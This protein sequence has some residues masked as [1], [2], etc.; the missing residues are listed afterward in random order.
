M[1]EPANEVATDATTPRWTI[2]SFRRTRGMYPL[3][4]EAINFNL[5]GEVTS[6]LP[7]ASQHPRYWSIYTY[8]VKRFWDTG[9]TPQTNTALGRYLKPRELVF[10]TAALLCDEHRE[11]PGI[12]GRN[13]IAPQ[14]AEGHPDLQLDLDYLGQGLGGYGQVYRGAMGDLGLIL[15]EENNPGVRLDA[16]FGELGASVADTF[17]KAIAGTAYARDHADQTEGAIPLAV[18]K[19]LSEV[20]CFHRLAAGGDERDLLLAVLVGSLQPSHSGHR[21]RASTVQMF[22]DL[23]EATSDLQVDEERFRRLLYWGSD[24]GGGSWRPSPPVET[25][26]RRWW[27]IRHREIVAGVLNALFVHFVVWGLDRGGL[28]RSL[29]ITEYA[30]DA[31]R[32]RPPDGLGLGSRRLADISLAETVAAMDELISGDGWPM[33]PSPTRLQEDIILHQADRGR[34]TD[35]PAL[36]LTSLLL[37]LRRLALFR[38]AADVSA[39]ERSIMRAGGIELAGTSE[40]V[41][42][43][44][45]RMAAGD[46]LADA[47]F[48]LLRKY[49]VHQHLRTARGKLPEDTFRFHE[50]ADSYRFVDQGDRQ[51]LNAVSIRFNAVA[52]ALSELGLVSKPFGESGHAPT[53]LGRSLPDG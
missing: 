30:S 42:W 27:L 4:L 32:T 37:A 6:G 34:A 28:L 45:Q 2:P 19:E 53:E 5:L 51:G 12:I 39:A 13:T 23:A 24:P 16:P 44:G 38:S 14:L 31:S 46:S 8:I 49:V 10:A 7:V 3:G 29:P 18:V 33:S 41:A 52:S 21:Q 48:D 26:W 15:H 9:Q 25:T 40:L 1:A 47:H 50:D 20:S 35:T 22:L 11:L 36:A 43:L 17:A